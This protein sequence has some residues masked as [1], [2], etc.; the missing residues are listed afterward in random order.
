MD[1]KPWSNALNTHL[2]IFLDSQDSI[3][4][5]LTPILLLAGVFLPMLMSNPKDEMAAFEPYYY[6]GILGVG[7]GD[8]FAVT[9]RKQKN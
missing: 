1:I 6:S 7:V 5:I 4:L 2:L 9:F 3:Q 8:G